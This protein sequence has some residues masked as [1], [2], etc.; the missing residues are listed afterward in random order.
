[1]KSDFE[2]FC[3]IV[4][5]CQESRIQCTQACQ[6][7]DSEMV[8]NDLSVLSMSVMGFQKKVWRGGGWVCGV[9]SIQF[10][11]GRFEFF[12]FAKPLTLGVAEA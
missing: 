4:L 11:W 5:N 7:C 6:K 3:L 10:D 8:N 2:M 12:N 1:M 9:S